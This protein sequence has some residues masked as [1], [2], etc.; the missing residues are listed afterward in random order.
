MKTSKIIAGL[1]LAVA[2]QTASAAVRAFP[3]QNAV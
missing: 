3:R 2:V 1:M